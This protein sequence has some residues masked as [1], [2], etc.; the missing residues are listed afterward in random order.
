MWHV[1]NHCV[2]FSDE[3]SHMVI[4]L[5]YMTSCVYIKVYNGYTKSTFEG[6]NIQLV[7]PYQSHCVLSS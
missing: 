5:N 1:V 2:I 6:E 4:C 7:N 3:I